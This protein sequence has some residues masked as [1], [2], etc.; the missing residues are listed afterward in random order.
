[1][2]LKEKKRD[3]FKRVLAYPKSLFLFLAHLNE[4]YFEIPEEIAKWVGKTPFHRPPPSPALSP[5]KKKKKKI[6][7]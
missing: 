6:A 3:Y 4:I 7:G 1:M 5:K 2:A